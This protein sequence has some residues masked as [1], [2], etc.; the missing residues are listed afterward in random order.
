[1]QNIH[2]LVILFII[3]FLIF[4]YKNRETF[5]GAMTQMYARGPI[6][7]YLTNVNYPY[8]PDPLYLYD[9]PLKKSQSFEMVDPYEPAFTYPYPPYPYF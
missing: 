1:M 9:E 6:D 4:F 5:L 8:S 3:L 2:I 7:G